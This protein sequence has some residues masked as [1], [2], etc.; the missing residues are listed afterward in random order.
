MSHHLDRRELLKR[1]AAGAAVLGVAPMAL[2]SQRPA[3]SG[4]RS[5]S[6]RV[7]HMT[8]IHVQP[9][10][11][12]AEG[13][14]AALAHIQSLEEQPQL[15]LTGG[16]HIMDSFSRDETRTRV[17]WDLL[18]KGFQNGCSVPVM[19][20][21]GNHD[22]WGWNR[23]KS[24]TSGDEPMWGK[25]WA[26]DQL[27]MARTYHSFDRGGW[28]FVCLDS[29]DH[30]PN[31]PDGYIGRLGEEQIDW[32]ERDLA[33]VPSSTPVLVL[34]HIPILTVTGVLTPPDEKTNN[35]ACSGGTMHADSVAI[36]DVFARHPNVKVCLSGHTHRIDRVDF[37]GVSYLCNG[38]VSGNWWKGVHYECAEGYSVL[39]LYDDGS[40]DNRYVTYG[41]KVTE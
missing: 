15:I 5:R 37:K 12:A 35:Y 6:L 13:L 24:K 17:Q 27:G 10:R 19:H 39:D 40:F 11:R 20:A 4:S 16:D 41:W 28:H 38:A 7:V 22:V 8:D 33:T 34:S 14:D 32:L 21:L 2:G 25:K 1:A 18:T 9:E 26:L 31:N 3:R 30:D 23:R 29:V 36:R